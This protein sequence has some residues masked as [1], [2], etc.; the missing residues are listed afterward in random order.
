MILAPKK[1]ILGVA[2]F[3]LNC[4]LDSVSLKKRYFKLSRDI[5]ICIVFSNMMLPVRCAVTN[6][7]LC[8]EFTDRRARNDPS[9]AAQVAQY[10]SILNKKY[11]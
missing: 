11:K 6:Q 5:Y 9:H 1:Y 7:N 4:S 8:D 2:F 10:F 3:R